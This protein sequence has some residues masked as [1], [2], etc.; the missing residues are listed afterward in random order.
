MQNKKWYL[1]AFLLLCWCSVF[2][3]VKVTVY[4]NDG[5]S[6]EFLCLEQGA[7]SFDDDKLV[8]NEGG[9]VYAPVYIAR[10]EIRKLTFREL[11]AAIEN[12][13]IAGS[14]RIYPNPA[15]SQFTISGIEGEKFIYSIFSLDGRQIAGGTAENGE[16]I[17]SSGMSAGVYLVKIGTHLLKLI[18]I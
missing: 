9:I 17:D 8:I 12:V 10:S 1:S 11:S 7:L 6:A 4:K 2:S 14:A 15:K 16:S 3:Q 5:T 18:K 13:E